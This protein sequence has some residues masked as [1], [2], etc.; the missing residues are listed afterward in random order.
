[1]KR[2]GQSISKSK[3]NKSTVSKDSTFQKICNENKLINNI[4]RKTKNFPKETQIYRYKSTNFIIEISDNSDIEIQQDNESIY[5]EGS[6]SEVDSIIE[7]KRDKNIKIN[8]KDSNDNSIIII[9]NIVNVK[10]IIDKKNI[11]NEKNI[12]EDCSTI[13]EQKSSNNNIEGEGENIKKKSDNALEQE[14]CEIVEEENNIIL[15]QVKD[16][17]KEKESNITLEQEKNENVEGE[18]TTVLDQE[19]NENIDEESNTT[20]R[21]EKDKNIKGESNNTLEKKKNETIKEKSNNFFKQEKREIIDKKKDNIFEQRQD[22]NNDNNTI[23]KRK[24]ES[25]EEEV[26]AVEKRRYNRSKTYMEHIYRLKMK[27]SIINKTI[28][29]N[30]GF[31]LDTYNKIF[32]NN[33]SEMVNKALDV[34]KG[35]FSKVPPPLNSMNNCYK[36]IIKLLNFT[37]SS[38]KELTDAEDLCRILFIFLINCRSDIH[39]CTNY[40]CKKLNKKPFVFI[41]ETDFNLSNLY[42]IFKNKSE[43]DL[44]VLSNNLDYQ[45][46]SIEYLLL[47]LFNNYIEFR[48]RN[49][50][51]YPFPIK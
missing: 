31:I 34:T 50:H 37:V 44:I 42:N 8:K 19:K 47:H 22:V 33:Q 11:D 29:F 5:T 27:K 1:I 41:P 14:E 25:E 4:K 43:K 12:C 16:K 26:V 9:N 49:N 3:F 7:Q 18:S 17:K 13:D 35:I 20:L 28:Y 48:K 24:K 38:K 39:I 23:R 45:W 6:I 2:K 46:A 40:C 21:Q 10:S 15:E 36:K 51:I 30:N 32:K